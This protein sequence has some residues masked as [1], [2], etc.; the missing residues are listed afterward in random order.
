MGDKAAKFGGSSL[1]TREDFEHVINDIILPDEEMNYVTASAI[2]GKPKVTDL[3]ITIER[4]P[5]TKA[6]EDAAKLIKERIKEVGKKIP[7]TAAELC[8]ELD[9]RIDS[10]EEIGGNWRDYMLAFGEYASATLMCG[11]IDKKRNFRAEFLDPIEIG[12]RTK[13]MNGVYVAD[14]DCIDRMGENITDID[15]PPGFGRREGQSSKV[16][17]IGIMPGFYLAKE[18]DL[19]YAQGDVRKVIT[20][21]PRNGSD[22]SGAVLAAAVRASKYENWTDQNGLSVI[23]PDIVKEITNSPAG[24]RE[25]T[26]Q[27]AR[28]LSYRD[29]K[30]HEDTMDPVMGR[31]IP[32]V[33][34][35]TFNPSHPGTSI[36]EDRVVPPEEYI[37]GVAYAAEKVPF[38]LTKRLMN[39]EMG[40]MKTLFGIINE[41]DISVEHVT[42]G[43]DSTTVYF[44]RSDVSSPGNI[45]DLI[46][47]VKEKFEGE[48]V[49]G[50][51]DPITVGKTDSIS[52]IAAVGKGLQTNGG[53][54]KAI[55]ALD[56]AGIHPLMVDYGPPGIGLFIGVEPA[57]AEPAM[58]EIY[59]AFF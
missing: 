2:G 1:K 35:N 6:A 26:F 37:V 9:V 38:N 28:E 55:S 51:E 19:S 47:A 58:R 59:K 10:R 57:K 34:R 14:L 48:G 31:M 42:T 33:V 22:I 16:R 24:V 7:D 25:M 52:I 49:A 27:E 29:F 23:H 13:Y 18:G 50:K 8:H 5:D 56:N 44:D 40:F 43:I 12:F 45:N 39:Q 54:G 20:T 53:I 3:I 36:V 21:L 17:T 15:W 41:R 32:I 4:E 30:L 46:R 11:M